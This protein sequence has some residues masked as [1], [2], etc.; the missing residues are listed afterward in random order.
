MPITALY[1]GL[2]TVLLIVLSV[3]VIAIRRGERVEIG[4]GGDKELLRRMRVHA[5]FIE[6]APYALILMGLAE[7]LKASPLLLHALGL[8][9]VTGRAIH[10]YALSQTPHIMQL[11]VMGMVLTFTTLGIAAMACIV[12]ALGSRLGM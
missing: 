9:L 1:A 8:L 10:A 5:N 11:R 7:L 12:L 2:L 3:R 6:Y 4:D